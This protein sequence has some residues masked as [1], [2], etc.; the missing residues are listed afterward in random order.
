MMKTPIKF[1]HLQIFIEVARQKSVGRAADILAISQPAV[2]KTIRELE[3]ILG[4]KL[5]E[6]E[7]RGI[8]L[9]RIGEVFLRHAGAS[10]ASV[11]QGVD[12][13]NQA[14]LHSAPPV[15]IGALPTVSAR[16]M[17]DAIKLYLRENVGSEIKI[18]TGEN[19]VLL[20]QLRSAEL[21]L[22]VGRLAAPEKMTGLS[23][24]HLYSEQVVFAVRAGHPLMENINFR[25]DELRNY[26]ML[27]PTKASVIRPFVERFLMAN[28]IP[29]LPI[30]IE[31]VSDSFGRAFIRS[32]DGIWIISEGVISNDLRDNRMQILPIDTSE[33]RGAVGLT[34]RAGAEENTALSIMSQSIR[35]A[36][37]PSHKTV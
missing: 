30:Q 6:K 4:V 21:D 22:V 16:I 32:S 15:R 24:E 13:V 33:T 35:A 11:L 23:F 2:T 7:G 17:P 31:T 5:F 12:S 18:V 8:K 3:E 25:L 14:L 37:A 28:G 1:R 20:E 29:E 10:V 27:M 36:A 19:A 26:T 9:G 34:T